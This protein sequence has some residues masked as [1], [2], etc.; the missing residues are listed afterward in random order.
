[1]LTVIVNV[2][3][4]PTGGVVLLAVFVTLK[5]VCGTGVGVEVELLLPGVGSFWSP[6][7]VAVFA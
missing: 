4:E 7:M 1:M 6:E 3:F 2:M 5:S